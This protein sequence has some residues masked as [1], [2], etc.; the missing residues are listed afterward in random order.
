MYATAFTHSLAKYITLPST[1]NKIPI[2]PKE[3]KQEKRHLTV[4]SNIPF[5]FQSEKI[6]FLN[7]YEK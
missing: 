7:F 6:G 3:K 2:Q 5:V 1:I 4:Y